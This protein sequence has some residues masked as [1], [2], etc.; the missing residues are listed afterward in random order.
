MDKRKLG[1]VLSGGG[2]RGAYQVGVMAAMS[3]I[4]KKADVEFKIDI[5]SGV[6]AGAINAAFLAA[7]S[8]DLH[9][10]CRKLV[11]LWSQLRS[12]DVFYTDA[13]NLGKI[14]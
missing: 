3:E 9:E 12:E 14:G 4:L 6:S 11:E 7:Q 8:H 5:F 2:A 13:T 10:G 1:L